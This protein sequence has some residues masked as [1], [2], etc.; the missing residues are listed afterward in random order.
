MMDAFPPEF[1][2][3]GSQEMNYRSLSRHD[4]H[5]FTL[6]ATTSAY[7][8]LSTQNIADYAKQLA[9]AFFGNGSSKRT[10]Q[11]IIVERSNQAQRQT[12]EEIISDC[13]SRIDRTYLA[14]ARRL[15]TGSLTTEMKSFL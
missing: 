14:S 12:L 8:N 3:P 2:A 5:T 9:P 11:I 10:N 4:I 15:H 7:C 6:W 13:G 1:P